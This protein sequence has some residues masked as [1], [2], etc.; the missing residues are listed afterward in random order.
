MHNT[1]AKMSPVQTNPCVIKII[2]DTCMQI[3]KC[4]DISGYGKFWTLDEM[5]QW[6][7][8]LP[9]FPHFLCCHLEQISHSTA[10]WQGLT[11]AWHHIQ[12]SSLIFG[13]EKCGNMGKFFFHW[14]ISSNV[15]NL[16]YPEM[17]LHL[18]ICIHVSKIIF[19][20]ACMLIAGIENGT[21]N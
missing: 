9:I 5:F 21:L 19:I 2:L 16:P 4:N 14:N 11:G 20:T 15:S 12:L 7:K 3:S 17:S 1:Q 6:K 10:S 13:Y 18:L 8:N